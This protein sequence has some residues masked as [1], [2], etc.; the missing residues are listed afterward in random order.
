MQDGLVL[1]RFF[2]KLVEVVNHRGEIVAMRRIR[3]QRMD[4]CFC[5][6][7]CLCACI[8]SLGG[9]RCQPMS[10]KHYYA[11]GFQGSVPVVTKDTSIVMNTVEE[12]FMLSVFL[13]VFLLLLG[14]IQFCT[15]TYISIFHYYH[16]YKTLQ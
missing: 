6:W 12:V 11:A 4:R 7:H 16:K 3:V 15:L 10:P 8:G 1:R 5:V 14:S 2:F 13:I 9:M